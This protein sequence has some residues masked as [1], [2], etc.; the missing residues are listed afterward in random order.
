M[1]EVHDCGTTHAEE[2]CGRKQFLKLGQRSV[3]REPF[4]LRMK[5]HDLVLHEDVQNFCGRK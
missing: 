5:E 2:T 1:I 4:R 3:R